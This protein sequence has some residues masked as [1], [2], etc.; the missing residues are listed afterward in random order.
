MK[1]CSVI[2][3]AHNEELFI[4]KTLQ[5]LIKQDYLN[6]E[7]VVIDNKSSDAT[8]DISKKFTDSVISFTNKINASAARNF[9]VKNSRG[10][11][12]AFLDADSC[13]SSNAISRSI[14]YLDEG[15]CGGTCKII[16]P[17]EKVISKMQT[18]ILNKWP[19]FFGPMYTPFVYTSRK[20]FKKTGGWNE[21]I[22]LADEID[23]QR[24]LLKLGKLKFDINSFVSTSPRRYIKKGYIR[25]SFFGV[26]G[27]VGY[28]RKWEPIRLY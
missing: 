27:Y 4:E 23:F 12:L 17:E 28:N 24:K 11:Y 5:S 21:E 18:L 14:K 13:L 7:I 16:P 19:R 15:Y 20:N 9:G 26:L 2:I 8:Y 1:T 10:E 3:P 22:E 6:L 25:T